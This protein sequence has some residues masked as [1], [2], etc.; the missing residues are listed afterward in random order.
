MSMTCQDGMA[1]CRDKGGTFP[2]QQ[3]THIRKVGD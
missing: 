1:V 3:R 2:E